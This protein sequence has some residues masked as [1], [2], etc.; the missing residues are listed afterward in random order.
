MIL[1]KRS[2]LILRGSGLAEYHNDILQMTVAETGVRSKC[3]QV[4]GGGRMSHDVEHKRVHI[5]GYS[6]AFGPAVHEVTAE[7]VRRS[8]PWYEPDAITVS[9]EGY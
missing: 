6:V 2:K 9:Y 3:F 7:L 1:G 8:H 5:Y 4:L